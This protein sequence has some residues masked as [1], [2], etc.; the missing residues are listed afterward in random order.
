MGRDQCE[1]CAKKPRDDWAVI[2]VTV[3]WWAF[4][5]QKL[6]G[7]EQEQQEREQ[8]Q[9]GQEWGT[10]PV[11]GTRAGILALCEGG[12]MEAQG[13]TPCAVCGQVRRAD[14]DNTDDREHVEPC[15]NSNLSI[16]TSSRLVW[17]SNSNFLRE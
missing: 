10:G 16:K 2:V 4:L 11:I 12:M 3:R 14:I 7:Q 17:K 9:Q 1:R 8:E 5:E 6:Q 15:L 13:P